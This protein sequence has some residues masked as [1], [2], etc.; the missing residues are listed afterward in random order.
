MRIFVH[1]A[2]SAISLRAGDSTDTVGIFGRTI[3]A[4]A[5]W[6]D[7]MTDVTQRTGVAPALPCSGRLL[8]PSLAPARRWSA[9]LA[10]PSSNLVRFRLVVL[11]ASGV[12]VGPTSW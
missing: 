9:S 7:R 1:S 2:R 3:A 5:E 6:K 10:S 11:L 12:V 8:V 4:L